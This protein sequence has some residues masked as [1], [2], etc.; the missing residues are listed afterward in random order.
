MRCIA[1]VAALLVG[2][3]SSQ[4]RAQAT[5]TL[6]E[7]LARA[8]VGMSEGEPGTDNPRV[9]GP[10][11]EE[12]A[13]RAAIEQ[14]RLRPN[15]EL[16]FEAENLAG[17]GA[18]SGLRSSEYTLAFEQQIELG[19]KRSARIDSAEA[20][21]RVAGVQR[22]MTVAQLALAVRERYIE[23]V[24]TGERV[25]LAREVVE[26]NRELARVAAVLVDVG[27]EPPLRALRA[28][29]ALA[30]ADADLQAAEADNLAARH[31]L[32]ALWVSDE[33][34]L[35]V[36][37]F[38]DLDP[39]L[40]AGNSTPPLPL[41]LARAGSELADAEIA[42]ERSLGILDPTISAGVRRFEGS[43]DQALVFGVTI[44]LPFGNHNQGNIAAAEA[45]ARAAQAEEAIAEADFRLDF[46]RTRTLYLAA[47]QRV[48][49]LTS[50]SLPQAEEALRLV[51][52]GYRN[53]R[54][55]LIE[56]LAAAEARDAIRQNLIEAEETR[57]L[58]A[59]R[60]IWLTAE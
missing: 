37:A 9:Y 59:A 60:L 27:R 8:G 22:E 43:N 41:R 12:E 14:A 56:V 31:A 49:T 18:F 40:A 30:E 24:A 42:R 44:P 33:P 25:E 5:I 16:T 6:D 23:A 20:L 54:F 29:A 15:P 58:L 50:A 13:A 19:G 28:Q 35:V 53:G 1:L 39:P 48:E 34:P 4:A 17:T 55:P 51:E 3:I 2:T 7:A 46:E 11:A 36:A 32:A 47:E 10:V 52:I 57:A 45:Q 21:A 38:P 26:R